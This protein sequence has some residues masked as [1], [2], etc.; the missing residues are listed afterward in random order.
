[1]TK[2]V[3][4]E[5]AYLKFEIPRELYNQFVEVCNMEPRATLKET[6][7]M[8]VEKYVKAFREEQS[9]FSSNESS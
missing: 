3:S 5:L 9:G 2:K 6:L 4:D 7:G 8:L 1:M